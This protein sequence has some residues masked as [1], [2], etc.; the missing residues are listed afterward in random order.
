M[1]ETLSRTVLDISGRALHVF[2]AE[3][4]TPSVG[5]LPTE[6]VKHFFYSF[7]INAGITLHQEILYGENDHHKIESLFKG[8]AKALQQAV[9]ITDN[10]QSVPS[11]KGML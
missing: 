7:A 8:L 6:M 3:F 2:H 9:K 11:T 4:S 1:D 5:S 10:V